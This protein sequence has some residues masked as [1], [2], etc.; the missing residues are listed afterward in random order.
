METMTGVLRSVWRSVR[1]ACLNTLEKGWRA[2]RVRQSMGCG[3][4]GD[5]IGMSR[6]GLKVPMEEREEV[7]VQG[8]ICRKKIYCVGAVSSATVIGSAPVVFI[9]L[10]LM[11][12][13]LLSSR[14]NICVNSVDDNGANSQHDVDVD[15]RLVDANML[16]ASK[17]P[18]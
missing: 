2:G 13:S 12:L 14:Q 1:V 8:L 16:Q 18:M 6:L 7:M 9:C 10:E 5:R 17:S 11:L 15:F 3:D 4:D